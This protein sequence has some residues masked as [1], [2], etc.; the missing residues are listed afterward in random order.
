LKRTSKAV[1]YLRRS[2]DRHDVSIEHQRH[3][4]G[5]LAAER[6]YHVVG[7]YRNVVES[8]KVLEQA[9]SF[10]PDSKAVQRRL[11]ELGRASS[12]PASK[13]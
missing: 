5:K 2:K 6:G 10:A 3:E 8:G 11:A 4:L 13:P 7:E 12:K 9:L 1:L